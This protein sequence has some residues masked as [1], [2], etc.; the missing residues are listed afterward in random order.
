[1][2]D[3][4]PRDALVLIVE[5]NFVV[6]DA[7]RYLIDGLDGLVA[8]SFPTLDRAFAALAAHR[9]DLAVLDVNLKGI[10][11]VPLAEQLH[12]RRIPF[13]FLTGYGDDQ[14]LPEHLRM[15]PRLSKPVDAEHLAHTLRDL[16]AGSVSAEGGPSPDG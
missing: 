12:A 2:T 5:D 15:Y 8:M 6:A 14:L 16:A 1:M 11:V 3:A 10:S 13:L 9:F 7:L 4:P